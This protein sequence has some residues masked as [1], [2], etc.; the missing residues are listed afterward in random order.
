MTLRSK[1]T[2][3]I[4]LRL[5]V[6]RALLTHGTPREA[7]RHEITLESSSS[8]GRA[9][10]VVALD[11]GLIGIEIKSGKDTLDRLDSQRERYGRRFDR[12][13]LVIDARHLP[14]DD[15]DSHEAYV[16]VSRLNFGSVAV[17]RDGVLGTAPGNYRDLP[18]GQRCYWDQRYGPSDTQA[19]TAM[20]S[21]LWASEVVDIA[22][23][24]VWANKI[25]AAG[26]SQRC[27]LIP[28]LAEHAPIALLR[29][30]IAQALRDR[31]L[32]RWEEAFWHEFDA[33][34]QGAAAE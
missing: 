5:L 31:P 22:A 10:M 26:G 15:A 14:A 4:D 33:R 1:K 32:N 17:V 24:L 25:P 6:T 27:R 23:R 20:L 21:M 8:D 7:I 28:H 29:P 30:A 11:R 3:D 12:L 16:I 13:C 2:N 34:S 18:W 9:D 19:P